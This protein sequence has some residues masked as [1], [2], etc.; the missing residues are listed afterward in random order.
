[1]PRLSES[2]LLFLLK[3]VSRSFYLSVRCLP[4]RIRATVAVGYL[5]ARASDSIADTNKL[6]PDRRLHSLSILGASLKEFQPNLNPELH[7]CLAAHPEGAERKLLANLEKILDYVPS[8]PAR[9]QELLLDVLTKIIHG[10]SLDIQR[11]EGA[12]SRALRT[13][14]ELDEYTYLVAGS[15]GE[16]WT[17]LC[18]GEWKSYS[19]ISRSEIAELGVQFGKGLQLINILRDFPVDVK[20]GRSYLPVPDLAVLQKDLQAAKDVYNCWQ[21]KAV[22]LMKSAWRYVCAVRPTRVRFACALPVLIGVRTLARLR[23]MSG[24]VSGVKVPRAEVY[25]LVALAMIV[26]VAPAA[27]SAVYRREFERS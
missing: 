21:E 13:E 6:E 20:A 9:H 15:V 27:E 12:G 24:I 19:R 17:E 18:L 16:F 25:W 22:G 26:A 4:E 2:E 7:A 3:T 11:F 5:V 10:Q 8:L 1:V 14:D 23:R